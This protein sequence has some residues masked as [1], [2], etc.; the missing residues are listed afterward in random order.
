MNTQQAPKKPTTAA[1][2]S[3]FIS[4]AGQLYNGEI[5]KGII[6]FVVQLVLAV[7]IAPTAGIAFIPFLV[8]WIWS[9]YDAHQFAKRI[10]EEAAQQMEAATKVCPS[11]TGRVNKEAQ[12]CVFCNHQFTPMPE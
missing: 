9:I 7:L 6:I 5:K 11:C 10:N 2:L 12:V 3:L 4:G 8:V 1:I